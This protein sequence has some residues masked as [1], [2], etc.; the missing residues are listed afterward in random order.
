MEAIP[1]GR[2]GVLVV[3]SV[4][5]APKSAVDFA[6]TQNQLM[7]DEHASG[8]VLTPGHVM[9]AFV[10][11][12][13]KSYSIFIFCMCSRY[14]IKNSVQK[15]NNSINGCMYSVCNGV[16]KHVGSGRLVNF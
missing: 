8:P 5:K 15:K 13:L 2:T 16:D 9:P 7:V 14:T 10:Q 11:V 3:A 6:T 1:T 4:V 12:E